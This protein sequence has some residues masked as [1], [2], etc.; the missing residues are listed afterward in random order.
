MLRLVYSCLFLLLLPLA[1]L[2][3]WRKGRKNKDYLQHWGERLGK[4]SFQLQQSIWLHAV[5]MGEMVAA[6]PLIQTLLD[7]QETLFLTC[8]TPTGRSEALKW[9]AKYPQQIFVAYLPY[10]VPFA[11]RRVVKKV[12]PKLLIVMETELWPNLFYLIKAPIIIANARIS[13]RALAKYRKICSLMQ[14]LLKP[15]SIIAAQSDQD[16]ERFTTLGAQSIKVA[17]NIKY[18]LG[19]PCSDIQKASALLKTWSPRFVITAGSTHEGEETLLLKAYQILKLEYPQLLLIL[20]PRHPERFDRVAALCQQYHLKYLR[21]SQGQH[22]TNEDVF[23]VDT[24][25]QVKT[26]YALSDIVFVG[27]SLTPI[28]GHNILEAA[29]FGKPIIV[30]PFMQN[31]RKIV[32]EFLANHALMQITQPKDITQGLQQLIQNEAQRQVL[33]QNAAKMIK[34][35]RGSLNRLMQMIDTLL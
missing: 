12:N 35:N 32:A 4:I 28:G 20:I 31:A 9:Q 18:D 11:I 22:I 19:D 16:A 8:M 27:G 1:F 2:R 17:G 26:L 10:D 29:I 7:R 13:D 25:G 33:G 23:I 34:K 14:Y 5:S 21:Y 3:L 15:V 30:G 6:N 24:M